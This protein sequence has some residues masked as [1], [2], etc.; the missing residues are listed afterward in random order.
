MREHW[1]DVYRRKAPEALGWHQPR[2]VVSLDL[3]GALGLDRAAALVDVGGGA[4]TLVD[5]LLAE[6]FGDV[7]VLDLSDEALALARA[8]LGDS[9]AR[10]A[11]IAADVTRWRPPRRYALWHDRAVLHFLI[12]EDRR[13]AY[14]DVLHRALAPGGYAV[15]ATFAPDGPE[16]CS[17]L[18]VRRHAPEDVAA[19]LGP[20]FRLVDHRHEDHTTPGGAVQRFQ[21]SVLERV[22]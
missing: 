13:Q 7:T 17:G 5:A 2:P 14:R 6:G 19:L 22:A 9:A 12:D 10:V 1:D 4:S 20:A 16:Q 8:R 11:W 21:Y 3:I 18:P 15:I